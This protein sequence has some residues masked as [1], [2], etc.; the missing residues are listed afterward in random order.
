MAPTAESENDGPG[1]FLLHPGLD[2]SRSD[3][4]NHPGDSIGHVKA[5]LLVH[6]SD[7]TRPADVLDD[8]HE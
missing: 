2:F 8:E 5:D 3:G 6:R 7:R 1:T 4:P